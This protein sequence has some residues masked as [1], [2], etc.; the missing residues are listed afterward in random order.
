MKYMHS[1]PDACSVLKE[2]A[3]ED[4]YI[5]GPIIVSSVL[6]SVALAVYIAID[7]KDHMQKKTDNLSDDRMSFMRLPSLKERI[8]GE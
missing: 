5:F 1:I 2:D 8:S 3:Q 7:V 6:I 4:S